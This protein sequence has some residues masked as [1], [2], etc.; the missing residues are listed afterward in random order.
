MSSPLFWDVTQLRLIVCYRRLGT[1]YRTNLNGQAFR[2]EGS[3]T[4]KILA[5]LLDPC[6][7]DR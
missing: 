6:K 2:Q 1:N 4:K 7:W 3:S 5:G